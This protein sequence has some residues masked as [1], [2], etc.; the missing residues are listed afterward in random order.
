MKH[1]IA[2][3]INSKF[4]HGIFVEL[5]RNFNHP[6]LNKLILLEDTKL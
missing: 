1:K 6:K 2:I 5:E 4:N 3:V